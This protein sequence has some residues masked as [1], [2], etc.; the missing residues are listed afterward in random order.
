M[1]K[2]TAPAPA[3]QAAAQPAPPPE[4]A[5]EQAPTAQ[6]ELPLPMPTRGGC[7]V[8]NP[9]GSLTSDPAEHPPQPSQE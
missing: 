9:D 8:R 5:P 1:A 3:A 4:P 6:P 7:W 2:T